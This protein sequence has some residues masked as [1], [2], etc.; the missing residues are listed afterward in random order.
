MFRMTARAG[1]RV[2]AAMTHSLRQGMTES[3]PRSRLAE[4]LVFSPDIGPGTAG[5]AADENVGVVCALFVLDAFGVAVVP[6]PPAAG[7]DFVGVIAGD[8]NEDK[9]GG[10]RCGIAAQP[11]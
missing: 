2:P 1:H 3:E 7:E 6:G 9:G 4:G 8:S 10:R 5:R 11:G